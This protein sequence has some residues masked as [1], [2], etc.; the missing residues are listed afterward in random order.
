M[1]KDA[2]HV[3]GVPGGEFCMGSCSHI[4]R[5]RSINVR[6]PYIYQASHNSKGGGGKGQ[7]PN[8]GLA[9]GS[10]AEELGPCAQPIC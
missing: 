3:R 10:T 7:G 2:R 1:T 4:A 6:K 8:G 9:Q 5:T